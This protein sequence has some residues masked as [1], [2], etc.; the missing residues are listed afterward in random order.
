[1]REIMLSRCAAVAPWHFALASVRRGGGQDDKGERHTA[2]E[3]RSR[4]IVLSMHCRRTAIR[5][6]GTEVEREFD[7]LIDT[8]SQES[9]CADCAADREHFL[10]TFRRI[11]RAVQRG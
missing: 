5:A 9:T 7:R 6:S 1:V 11:Y 8:L 10:S 2:A 3:T 4:A